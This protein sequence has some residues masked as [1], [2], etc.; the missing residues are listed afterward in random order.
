[1]AN[2]LLVDDHSL[3]L[4]SLPLLIHK[5]SDHK[6]IMTCDDAQKALLY[7]KKNHKEIDLIIT[8]MK[9]PGIHGLE[10]IQKLKKDFPKVKSLVISQYDLKE[11]VIQ[12]L[13]HGASGYVLKNIR[14]QEMIFAINKILNGELY[15]CNRG[16]KVVIKDNQEKEFNLALTEREKEILLLISLGHTNKEIAQ[17]LSLERSTISFHRKNLMSKIDAHNTADIT[18]VAFRIGLL[19]IE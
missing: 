5:L 7:L 18:R 4:D 19:D 2:I 3:I 9:M 15:L 17:H 8:D 11:Y 1:M 14:A 12:S 16:L 10:F 13:N 6:I